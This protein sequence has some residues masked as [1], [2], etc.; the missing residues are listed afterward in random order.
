M[1]SLIIVYLPWLLSCMT[2]VSSWLTGNKNKFGWIV[3]LASQALW[4]VWIFASRNWGFLP[5]N[6][7]LWIVYVR[8][9][10]AWSRA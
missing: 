5:L 7:M 8:N 9:Y 4:L 1:R 10:R 6:A 3:A 2:I